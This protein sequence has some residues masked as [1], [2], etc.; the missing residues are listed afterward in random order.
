M[1]IA[2]ELDGGLAADAEAAISVVSLGELHAGVI[3][4]GDDE[5][6]AARLARLTAI[7]AAGFMI[8]PVTVTVA[9]AF[10][11]IVGL[12]RRQERRPKATDALIAATAVVGDLT[13]LTR[14]RD[15]EELEVEAVII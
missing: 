10:G 15:F 12:A 8:L 3:A 11:R 7:E 14:D 5:A 13:V 4:A 1:L 2:Q 6:R 9:R